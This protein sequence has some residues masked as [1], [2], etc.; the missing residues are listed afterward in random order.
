[1][2]HDDQHAGAVWAGFDDETR[3][4]VWVSVAG[5]VMECLK[6]VRATRNLILKATKE[7][8]LSERVPHNSS[9]AEDQ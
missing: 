3:D 6:V 8:S 7:N 4:L 5:M 9:L 1:M 2:F